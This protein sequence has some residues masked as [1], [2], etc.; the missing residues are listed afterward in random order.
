MESLIKSVAGQLSLDESVVRRGIGQVFKYCQKQVPEDHQEWFAKVPGA[1]SLI[2]E[3]E[4]T[5]AVHGTPSPTKEQPK[6]LVG[7]IIDFVLWLLTA[8][9]ILDIIKSLL[10]PFLGEDKTSQLLD[11]VSDGASLVNTL[12]GLG[13][14]PEKVTP[15]CQKVVAYMR[16][17]LGDEAVDELVTKIPAL[18]HLLES[19]RKDE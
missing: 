6:S 5:E 14:T 8:R 1:E 12:Q 13:I 11:S 19:A 9:F 4:A 2:R 15:L 16:E 10:S 18:G 17:Y 3:E 7:F